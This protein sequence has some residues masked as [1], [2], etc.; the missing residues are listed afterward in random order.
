[1]FHVSCFGNLDWAN[2]DPYAICAW[3][4]TKYVDPITN[5]PY[6]ADQ[7]NQDKEVCDPSNCLQIYCM[8]IL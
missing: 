8:F 5:I 7:L 6:A 4:N 2:K 3:N 1:M